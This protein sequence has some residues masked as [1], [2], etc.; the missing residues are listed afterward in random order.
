M[1]RGRALGGLDFV[2]SAMGGIFGRK[3]LGGGALILRISP[4]TLL[5]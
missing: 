1:G 5:P 3:K 4:F 2:Y